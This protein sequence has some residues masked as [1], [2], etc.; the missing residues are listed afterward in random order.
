M[1]AGPWTYTYPDTAGEG[2]TVFVLSTG[3]DLTHPEFEGRA[4][5]GTN[6]AGG[7]DADCNGVG[8]HL[9]GTVGAKT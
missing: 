1:G 9:A 6:V 4:V 8:T 5:F 2:V 7:S 3:I